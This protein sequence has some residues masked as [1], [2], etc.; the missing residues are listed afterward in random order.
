MRPTA[1]FG[2]RDGGSIQPLLLADPL[3]VF[4]V[5]VDSRIRDFVMVQEIQMYHCG[6]LGNG[7]V[8]GF[9]EILLLEIPSI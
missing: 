1:G 3:T 6:K 8:V 2:E 7:Q 9:R 4:A 5:E